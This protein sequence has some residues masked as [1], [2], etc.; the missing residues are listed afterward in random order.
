M[1]HPRAV[2]VPQTPPRNVE[3]VLNRYRELR[4]SHQ[5]HHDALLR[6][7][8]RGITALA[9]V[10]IIILV[11]AAR[12]IHGSHA[13][14]PLLLT[15]ALI[16]GLI[17]FVMRLQTKLERTRRLLLFYD[18]S[19]LRADGTEPYSQRTGEDAAPTLT[20]VHLYQ[21]D[22]DITGEKSLFA[23]L[24]TVRT[25]IGDRGLARYLLSPATYEETVARQQAVRELLP[26]IS[27]REHIAL[28]GQSSFQQLSATFFDEWLAESPPVFISIYRY[29]LGLTALINVALLLAG[30]FRFAEW[31]VLFPN[32]LA[33]LAVQASI[34]LLIRK[35]VLPLLEG[36]ARLQGQ[37]RLFS[38]GLALLQTCNFIS[39]KLIELQR[40]SREPAG[41]VK[42]LKQLDGYLVIA[43]QRTKELFLIFSLLLAAGSQTAISIALWK[44]RHVEAMRLWLE[45]WAEFEALNALATYA[46]E[47]PVED[48]QHTW[49]E[50]L[51]PTHAPTLEARSLGHPLLPTG[52]RNDIAL[53]PGQTFLLISG[54]NMAGKSTLMR[55]VGVA[56]VLAYAGA[57]VRASSLRL[58]PLA[59]GA[60]IAL[61]DSLA[62]GK[63]KFLA[64][65]ER[66]AA[67]VRLSEKEPVLF[68][69]DE[70]FSGTNSLDRRAAAE[71]VLNRL[72]TNQA[73]GA[74]STHDLALTSLAV[75]ANQGVNVHMASPDPSDP[76]A[77]DYLLK[78]G[79]N[80]Y[81]N[82]LAI[83]RLIGL[84]GPASSNQMV[85]TERAP[86]TSSS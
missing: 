34:A 56:A 19:I 20:G 64:E 18:Q 4:A 23:L 27:L 37:V 39:P 53:M 51:S 68:L 1:P 21:H 10:A 71:A 44:R 49:P 8:Q 69:V 9:V 82:A 22:L 45:A 46:F 13:A 70:I 15:F 66:L 58:S 57:P 2:P 52:V 29:A 62:E 81:S 5:E 33:A 11:Q 65:V 47:H 25:A 83:I 38:E 35:R 48:G 75:P 40:L 67:I 86:D 80:Q 26:Q 41:A 32:L 42:L 60:S 76:L 3:E 79:I 72:L 63:S 55:S 61:R 6:R 28:L 17:P 85:S 24:A 30:I 84:D 77:F 16:F 14:W 78:P 7:Q 74:L 31:S 36:S 54:S 59:V 12:S 43:E 73:I 50:L